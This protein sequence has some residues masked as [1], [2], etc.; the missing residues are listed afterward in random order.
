[1]TTPKS[2]A[3]WVVQILL[4]LLFALQGIIK[5]TSAP[6]WVAR[7]K[8]WGYP[9]HFY[10]AVGLGEL[11]GAILLLIPRLAR[12]G[13][14]ILMTVM[15]GAAATHLLHREP[16]VITTVILMALLGVVLYVR[17]QSAI[18]PVGK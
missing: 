4:A 2:V 18:A 15:I 11:V 9:D 1:V 6:A 16:Q 5:L 8:A 17:R 10:L 13:A 12:F 3:V 7:F 14:L